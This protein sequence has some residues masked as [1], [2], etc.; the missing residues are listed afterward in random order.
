[1]SKFHLLPDFDNFLPRPD[2]NHLYLTVRN[3]VPDRLLQSSLQRLVGRKKNGPHFL[4]Q[5][6][7]A[8]AY[9]HQM[10]MRVAKVHLASIIIFFIIHSIVVS[11]RLTTRIWIVRKVDMDDYTIL[12][13]IFGLIIGRSLVIAEIHY[14]FEKHRFHLCKKLFIEL[15][16]YS[17][18]EWIQTFP[19]LLFTKLS[20]SFFPSAHSGRNPI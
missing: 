11:L 18:G 7:P 8:G 14:G 16:K 17:Y 4:L 20:I 5:V 15:S 2:G 19:T 6:W 9:H 1:M 13:A 3:R 10:K 12:Y